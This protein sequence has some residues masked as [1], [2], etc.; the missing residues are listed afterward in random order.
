MHTSDY[1]SFTEWECF[2]FSFTEYNFGFMNIQ[3]MLLNI[4]SLNVN[5][6]DSAVNEP[7]CWNICTV[8]LFSVP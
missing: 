4:L 8:D 3:C 6:L 7:V 1:I 2:C 5:G